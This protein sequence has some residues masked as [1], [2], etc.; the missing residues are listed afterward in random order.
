M[1]NPPSPDRGWRGGGGVRERAKEET[2]CWPQV[3]FRTTW[4]HLPG[5]TCLG[6]KGEGEKGKGEGEKGEGEGDGLRT[7]DH[8]QVTVNEVH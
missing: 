5:H 3:Q 6:R 1:L 8:R 4:P 2:P 7:I